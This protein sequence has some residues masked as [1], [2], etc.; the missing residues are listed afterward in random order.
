M[1]FNASGLWRTSASGEMF[2]WRAQNVT[3][4]CV[5]TDGLV[6]QAQTIEA[7]RAMLKAAQEGDLEW[8]RGSTLRS[9]SATLGA[10]TAASSPTFTPRTQTR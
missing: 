7:K 8:T 4:V 6:M 10:G 5:T 2:P 3:F 9:T 1:R